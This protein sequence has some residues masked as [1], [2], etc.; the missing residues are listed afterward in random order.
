MVV[1]NLSLCLSPCAYVSEMTFSEWSWTNVVG[2]EMFYSKVRTEKHT[3]T[4][5]HFMLEMN[6]PSLLKF[7]VT[8][9]DMGIQ[10]K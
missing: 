1:H 4:H 10:Q 5:T 2:E 3:H 6:S 9:E 8:E 7:S